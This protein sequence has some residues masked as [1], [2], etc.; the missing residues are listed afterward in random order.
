[1]NPGLDAYKGKLAGKIL[2]MDMPE[3]HKQ[4]FSA[5]ASRYDDAALQKMADTK[6]IQAGLRDTAG[7]S[8]R[9][10]QFA[11]GRNALQL[12]AIIKAFAKAEGT[13]AMLC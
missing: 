10:T 1:M 5:D 8:A 11:G 7:L 6:P 3:S 9:R 4:S 12:P 13:I 2:L